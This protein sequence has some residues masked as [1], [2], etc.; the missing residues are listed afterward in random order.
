MACP[1]VRG[2][3][4]VGIVSM[5]TWCL[6]AV[7]AGTASRQLQQS[8]V[9]VISSQS[10]KAQRNTD[11]T[12]I[13]TQKLN[14]IPT[15]TPTFTKH[16]TAGRYYAVNLPK[17]HNPCR[18]CPVGYFSTSHH[19][20]CFACSPGRFGYGASKSKGCDGMCLAGRFGKGKSESASSNGLC[21]AGSHH[22]AYAELC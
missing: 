10:S 1:L 7:N 13:S 18:D 14:T 5:H 12:K 8:P 9:T 6:S 19:K 11:A 21:P 4:L 20:S 22:T 2:M 17:W 15:M 16:C 3:L